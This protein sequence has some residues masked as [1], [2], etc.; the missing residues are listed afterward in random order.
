M[1]QALLKTGLDHELI[2]VKIRKNPKAKNGSGKPDHHA[3]H[4]FVVTAAE[5]HDAFPVKKLVHTF[6]NPLTY[7][8]LEDN[9]D[10]RATTRHQNRPEN[11][12]I[13][14]ET[15]FPG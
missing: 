5:P 15:T 13:M 4:K 11:G 1:Q 14:T 8:E 2:G 7:T 9:K 6:A 12:G 10:V 3:R